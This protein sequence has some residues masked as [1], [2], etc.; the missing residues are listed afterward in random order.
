MRIPRKRALEDV[1]V[2]STC[3]PMLT[4][5]REHMPRQEDRLRFRD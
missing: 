3:T 4:M 1:L 2:G 5:A